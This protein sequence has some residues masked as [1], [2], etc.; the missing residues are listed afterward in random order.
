MFI[1]K[2]QKKNKCQ[3][4]E[5]RLKNNKLRYPLYTSQR[6]EAGDEYWGWG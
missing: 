2:L 1:V 3:K 6:H 5:L 4:P